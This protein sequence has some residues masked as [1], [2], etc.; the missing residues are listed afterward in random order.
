MFSYSTPNLNSSPVSFCPLKGHSVRKVPLKWVGI[1]LSAEDTSVQLDLRVGELMIVSRVNNSPH[2]SSLLG[3][4]RQIAIWATNNG[5][6]T[7]VAEYL[8]EG[9]S[10]RWIVVQTWPTVTIWGTRVLVKAAN[11]LCQYELPVS[12][13]ICRVA[14]MT[15]AEGADGADRRDQTKERQHPNHPPKTEISSVLLCF[16]GERLVLRRKSSLSLGVPVCYSAQLMM[17]N[18]RYIFF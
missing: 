17:G 1:S 12:W 10:T 6:F 18:P 8:L 16:C 2:Q 9:K 15:S 7:P 4:P 14:L 13:W 3:E 5:K 11:V